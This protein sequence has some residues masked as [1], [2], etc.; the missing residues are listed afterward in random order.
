MSLVDDVTVKNVDGP[1]SLSNRTKFK[2]YTDKPL[3]I[4]VTWDDEARGLVLEVRYDNRKRLPFSDVL[5][6]VTY[7]QQYKRIGWADGE[8]ITLSCASNRVEEPKASVFAAPNQKRYIVKVTPTKT[9]AFGVDSEDLL[10]RDWIVVPR[11]IDA[12][13]FATTI[14][15]APSVS[16]LSTLI[17]SGPQYYGTLKDPFKI[18]G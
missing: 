17:K 15:S 9:E 2:N 4:T 1:Y 8:Y 16:D 11:P 7:G 5:K 6:S 13:K 10:A 3:D 12:S 14:L 18:G